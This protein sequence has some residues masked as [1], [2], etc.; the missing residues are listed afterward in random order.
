MYVP[1][2]SPRTPA[3]PAAVVALLA[4]LFY[5]M[6]YA[7]EA[8][9]TP[10]VDLAKLALVTSKDEEED[11]ADRPGTE[12]SNDTDATLV[13]DAPARLRSPS[14]SPS[15][16]GKRPRARSRME[17]DSPGEVEREGYVGAERAQPEA[18]PSRDVEMQEAVVPVPARKATQSDSV[19]MFGEWDVVVLGRRADGWGVRAAA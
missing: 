14:P 19:M 4:E 9:I 11:E 1:P 15:V 8:A 6:K 5:N 17:V 7:D 3:E 18:G 16:L 10:K 13:E 12:G 2:P